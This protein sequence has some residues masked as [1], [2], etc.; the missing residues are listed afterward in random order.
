[1]NEKMIYDYAKGDLD[2]LRASLRA[3]D[4]SS[5]ISDSENIDNDW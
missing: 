1:M 4:L 2:G 3:T 5:L